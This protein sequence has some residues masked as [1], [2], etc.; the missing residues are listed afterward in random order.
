RGVLQLPHEIRQSTTT[1]PLF[2]R[3]G[4]PRRL[5]LGQRPISREPDRRR[6]LPPRTLPTRPERNRRGIQRPAHARPHRLWSDH[7]A[8][9]CSYLLSTDLGP[10]RAVVL[11]AL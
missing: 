1:E 2:P 4:A 5:S 9:L 10:R 11:C 6:L 7:I 3:P 8:L